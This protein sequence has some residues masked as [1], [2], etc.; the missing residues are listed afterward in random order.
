MKQYLDL[1]RLI[2]AEGFN[3]QDRTG[4]GTI[5]VFGAQ[6]KFDLQDGFPL[7]TTKKVHFKSVAYEL[8]WLLSGDTNIQFM[9][10]HGV[11]IWDEWA[12]QRGGLG[13]VYGA[14]WRD[15]RYVGPDGQ[16]CTM[17]Q[18]AM[19]IERIKN[20]PDDRRLIVTAWQPGELDQMA[21]PPCHCFFQFSTQLLTPQER[22]AL[23]YNT[24]PLKLKHDGLDRMPEIPTRRLHLQ[25]Y[26]RS[27]DTFLGVPF[28]IASYSLLLEMVAH[29]VG[30]QAGT[31]T[32]TYGDLHI[33]LNHLDQV[34]EQL[35]REPRPLPRLLFNRKVESIFDFTYD[36]FAILGYDPHPAIKA[37]ISV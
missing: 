29:V 23:A 25:M 4:T 5:G 22:F 24:N 28:N 12:D 16:P 31:F 35:T 30:M 18:I 19:V 3:R 33:Y 15:W 13:R 36:D 32:H 17:D 27:C 11:T 14:Q 37:P 20:K 26:Q 7:L 1:L 8:L 21:L 2:K 6:A 9:N 10:D 34:N